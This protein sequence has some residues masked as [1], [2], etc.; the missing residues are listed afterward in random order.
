MASYGVWCRQGGNRS[1]TS[2][3]CE[4]RGQDAEADKALGY[5]CAGMHSRIE[6]GAQGLSEG[7]GPEISRD[8]K[9]CHSKLDGTMQ[10][11]HQLFSPAM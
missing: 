5:V 7:M 9:R 8:K 11:E 4:G 2:V 10:K 6:T 3:A 1:R